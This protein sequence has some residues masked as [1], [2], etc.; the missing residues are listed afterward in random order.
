MVLEKKEREERQL[1]AKLLNDAAVSNYEVLRKEMRE[2]FSKV[3][4]ETTRGT[5]EAKKTSES[6]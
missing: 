1:K 2:Q 4:L 3:Q 5:E 6:I